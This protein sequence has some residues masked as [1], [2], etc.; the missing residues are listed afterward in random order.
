[1]ARAPK[2]SAHCCWV[3]ST[4]PF[5]QVKPDC[6]GQ[7]WRDGRTKRGLVSVVGHVTRAVTAGA[8]KHGLLFEPRGLLDDKD[9]LDALAWGIIDE[10]LPTRVGMEECEKCC[11]VCLGI[12]SVHQIALQKQAQTTPD[13]SYRQTPSRRRLVTKFGSAPIS[14]LPRTPPW[15]NNVVPTAAKRL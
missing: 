11:D 9:E 13:P 12:I 10:V 5:G 15:R 7:G 6:G 8:S 4:C 3:C 14:S 2:L 1:M